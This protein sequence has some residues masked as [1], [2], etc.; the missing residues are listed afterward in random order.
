MINLISISDELKDFPESLYFTRHFYHGAKPLDGKEDALWGMTLLTAG[1]MRF[2]WNET[3]ANRDEVLKTILK[4]TRKNTCSGSCVG[5]KKSCDCKHRIVPLELIHSKIVVQ[6][7][8]EADTFQ[9]KADGIITKNRLLV[10]TVTVADCVPLFLY[11]T[12]SK[13][14]GAFH[15]GWK[16]T[17]IIGEGVRRMCEAYDTSPENLCAAIG[18]H[19]G[20]CCYCVDEERKNYFTENFGSCC[21]KELAPEQI[22]QANS[23]L[24]YSLSLTEANLHVL[25]NS[26][27]PEENIVVAQ[28]CT[29]CSTFGNVKGSKNVFG[30]FRRQAA[31]LPAEISADQRS[32]SMTVQAAFVIR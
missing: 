30:S 2:R 20:S 18:P 15:S 16:G 29:C 32:R 11:D 8:K 4:E 24:K 13:A 26:G 17:G 12:K 23:S 9:V 31:F 22:S 27:I 1:S 19:I 14:T 5:E 25:K 7:E 21:I 28:D 6:A 10:P 3:N